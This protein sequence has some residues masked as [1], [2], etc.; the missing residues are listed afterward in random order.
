MTGSVGFQALCSAT[1]SAPYP[2]VRRAGERPMLRR[3][4]QSHAD[5]G[6][7]PVPPTTMFPIDTTGTATWTAERMLQA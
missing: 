3:W 7:F 2:R 5:T 4:S 1:S 6:V